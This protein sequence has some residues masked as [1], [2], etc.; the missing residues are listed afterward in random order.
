MTP[1]KF[2]HASAE[3]V[4]DHMKVSRLYSSVDIADAFK[5]PR[6][7]VNDLL[8]RL[9]RAGNV[10]RIRKE[11]RTLCWARVVKRAPAD[12]NT[13]VAGPAYAPDLKATM[14]GYDALFQVRAELAMMGR[15]R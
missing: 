11:D 8:H 4:L 5:V 1:L 10:E 13:S 12:L 3:K 9:A 6:Q 14:R 2:P 15:G 7:Y